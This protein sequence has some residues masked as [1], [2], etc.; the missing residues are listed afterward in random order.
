MYRPVFM[1]YINFIDRKVY[2][3]TMTHNPL[4]WYIACNVG[5][6]TSSDYSGTVGL[7]TMAISRVADMK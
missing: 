7:E 1:R 5:T 2:G 4:F 3:Q 6:H